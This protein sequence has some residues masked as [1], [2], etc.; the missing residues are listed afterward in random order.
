[1]GTANATV[2]FRDHTYLE[3]LGVLAATAANEAVRARLA[4][5]EG[6][7]GVAFK[8][9]DAQRAAERLGALDLADGAAV[10]LQRTVELPGGA[11]DAMFTLARTRPGATPG[12]WLFACQHHTPDVVWREDHLDHPNGAVGLAELVG[13]AED[14]DAIV[15]GWRP[16]FGDRLRVEREWV[17]LASRTAALTFST[18]A[19][20]RDRLGDAVV[21]V[22]AQP[23]LVAVRVRVRHLGRALERLRAAELPVRHPEVN[24]CVVPASAVF[25]MGVEL[26]P[27]H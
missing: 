5:V 23:H 13:V 14:L 7:Y 6:L 19:G 25:G 1:M 24:R 11:R 16:I 2:L 17:T 3:T 15:R 12:A 21:P 4:V 18:Q 10:E 8:T 27:A 22:L 9:P 26:V 20:L